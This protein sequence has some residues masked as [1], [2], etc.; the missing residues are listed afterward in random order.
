MCDHPQLDLAA[1]HGGGD[2]IAQRRFEAAQLVGQAQ[3]K[4]EEAAVDGTQLDGD[5]SA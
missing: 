4:I 3:R 1:P 5:A 2:G